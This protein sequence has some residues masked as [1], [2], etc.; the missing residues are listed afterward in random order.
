M[1]SH[2]SDLNLILIPDAD[3]PPMTLCD[4]ATSTADGVVSVYFRDIEQALLK[5]IAAADVV[6]GCVA[7]LTSPLLLH[8]LSQ[9]QPSH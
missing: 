2:D 8:A 4:P 1:P 5:H 6:V 9:K 3:S 7:W